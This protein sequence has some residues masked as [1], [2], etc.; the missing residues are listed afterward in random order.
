M[1]TVSENL[2]RNMVDNYCSLIPEGVFFGAHKTEVTVKEIQRAIFDQ[3]LGTT[4]EAETKGSDIVDGCGAN[5]VRGK[6]MPY[7][8][9]E[10]KGKLKKD[11]L[12][13]YIKVGKVN[14][15]FD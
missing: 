2:N 12:T 6:N 11:V 5:Y 7:F 8:L 14:F 15:S 3:N 13:L 10:D 4:F 1:N 9:V